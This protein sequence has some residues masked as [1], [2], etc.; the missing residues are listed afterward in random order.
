MHQQQQQDDELRHLAVFALAS[1][2]CASLN[3]PAAIAVAIVGITE[4]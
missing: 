2:S 1:D 3:P 4:N